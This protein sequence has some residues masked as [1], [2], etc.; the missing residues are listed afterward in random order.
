VT[1]SGEVGPGSAAPSDPKGR[2]EVVAAIDAFSRALNAADYEGVVGMMTDDARFWPVDS[3]EMAGKERARAAYAALEGFRVHARFDVDEV[4]VSGDLAV[5]L[6]LEYFRLEP[7]GGGA[8]LEIRGRRAF[9][10]W[11][12]DG[13]V[14]KS[15]RGMTNWAAPQPKS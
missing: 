1:T 6:A 9:S 8:P 10:V 13:G 5:V 11:R 7:K 12:R 4:L 14:W 2:E 15:A 3:A